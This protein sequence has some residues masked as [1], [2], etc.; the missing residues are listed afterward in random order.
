M[1]GETA[2]AGVGR[3]LKYG[4]S[5]NLAGG[6]SY[7]S[8]F[9]QFLSIVARWPQYRIIWQGMRSRKNH[10]RNLTTYKRLQRTRPARGFFGSRVGSPLK[11]IIRRFPAV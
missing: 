7:D 8:L 2:W 5:Y 6:S 10:R 11:R 1:F 4:R 3:L 9:V